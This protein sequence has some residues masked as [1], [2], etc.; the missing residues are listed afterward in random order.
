MSRNRYVGDYRLVET[1]DQRGRIRTDYEYIG[2]DYFFAAGREAA[3][4]TLTRA[5]VACGIGALAFVGA[6]TP[7]SAAT[8]AWWVAL[9]FA[10]V[11]LPLALMTGAVVRA[12]RAKEPLEHRHADGLENR[13]P[14]CSFFT[15][16]LSAAAL[17]GEGVNGIRG[18]DMLMGDIIF[19]VG[20]ALLVGV[21]LHNHRLWKRVRCVG[22]PPSASQAPPLE[23]GGKKQ[24]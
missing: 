23:R 13:C 7:L 16:L 6:L 22:T 14:A 24:G 2:A 17:I 10:F 4:R 9:P 19:A 12:L 3:H 15:M 5:L 18:A 1:I 20:A 8:H 21:G 11:V